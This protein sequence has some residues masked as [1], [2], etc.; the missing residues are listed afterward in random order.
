MRAWHAIALCCGAA[1][2]GYLAGRTHAPARVERVTEL[3]EQVRTI[4]VRERIEAERTAQ[5]VE[6]IIER[7]MIEACPACAGKASARLAIAPERQDCPALDPGTDE[8]TAW[9]TG[10]GRVVLEERTIERA[11]TQSERLTLDVSRDSHEDTRVRTE[12]ERIEA[13]SLPRWRVGVM[14]GWS[15]ADAAPIYGIEAAA[16]IV[17]PV[18]LGAWGMATREL[19]GAAGVSVGVRW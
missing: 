17:G 12:A 3:V 18:E 4:V 13:P 1:V 9:H 16:R 11:I 14:A 10:A 7:R 8:P 19:R 2:V 6:R 5:A 15:W